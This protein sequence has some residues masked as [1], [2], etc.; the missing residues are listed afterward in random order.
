[1]APFAVKDIPTLCVSEEVAFSP[2]AK[3]TFFS[4]HEAQKRALKPGFDPRAVRVGVIV[5][6]VSLGTDLSSS[7][8][9]FARQEHGD[10][11]PST[12]DATGS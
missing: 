11:H 1:M 9:T 6:S 3:M 2:E 10:I 8:S 7:T 12:M 4:M 5:D